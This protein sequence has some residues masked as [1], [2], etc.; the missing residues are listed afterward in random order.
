MS[1]ASSLVRFPLSRCMDSL[2]HSVSSNLPCPSIPPDSEG[3]VLLLK[4]LRHP[5]DR[6]LLIFKVNDTVLLILTHIN[7]KSPISTL[8]IRAVAI[9]LESLDVGSRPLKWLEGNNS[10]IHI[11]LSISKLHSLHLIFGLCF[12]TLC[13]PTPYDLTSDH[14]YKSA[15][16]SPTPPSSL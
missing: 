5:V 10:F 12:D 11:V 2:C 1:C 9:R 8:R 16:R 14:D 6:E 4:E 13:L 3:M 15:M 7:I